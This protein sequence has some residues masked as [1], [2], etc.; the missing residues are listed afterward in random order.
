MLFKRSCVRDTSV[1]NSYSLPKSPWYTA[2][3]LDIVQDLPLK[4][5]K[6][7]SMNHIHC[8]MLYQMQ[9]TW[10]SFMHLKPWKAHIHRNIFLKWTHHLPTLKPVLSETICLGR[11]A[12]S[13][14]FTNDHINT[15]KNKC[16]FSCKP[17]PNI[18]QPVLYLRIWIMILNNK[19]MLI[20]K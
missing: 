9:R 7:I 12:R 19:P 10:N 20:I 14:S 1:D 15:W 13:I 6:P 11:L 3:S 17:I 4:F 18:L 16:S 5:H 8:K 2:T